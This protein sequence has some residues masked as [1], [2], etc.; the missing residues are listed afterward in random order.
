MS[1]QEHTYLT[2]VSK[3]YNRLSL[4]GLPEHETGLHEVSLEQIFIKL[5]L[6]VEQTKRFSHDE[7]EQFASED[8][9]YKRSRLAS[10]QVEKQPLSIADAL[11]QHRRLIVLGA[12]GSGK[13]TLLRW[14]AVT[15]ANRQQAQADRLGERFVQNRLP[16]M[17]ELRRFV[18]RLEELAK[19][20]TTFKLVEEIA[21]FVDE[22]AH[23]PDTDAAFIQN[24]FAQGQCLL[25]CDGL[26]EIADLTARQRFLEALSAFATHYPHNWCILTSRPH[27]V[28]YVAD[29]Q[30]TEIQP[31][32]DEDLK[33][34]IQHWYRSVSDPI[35]AQAEVKA[36]LAQIQERKNIRELARNPLLATIVAI[37]YRSKQMLPQRRVE[38][39]AQS[40]EVLLEKWD[41]NKD[42]R[43]SGF[44]GQLD[45]QAKLKL[46]SPVAYWL[47]Q[48][49]E[50]LA[51]TEAEIEALLV[52]GLRDYSQKCSMNIEK[53]LGQVARQFIVA[54]RDRSGLLQGR[55][56]G[57]LEFMH[58][59]FQEYLCA[60]YIADVLSPEACLD[61]VMTHLHE[62][63]WQEVH[64]LVVGHLGTDSRGAKQAEQLLLAVLHVYKQPW[65][66]L[67]PRWEKRRWELGLWFPRWQWQRRI[68]WLLVREFALA[69]QM[70]AD[71]A[72]EGRTPAMTAALS[73][74]VRG[75]FTEYPR[76]LFFALDLVVAVS[77]KYLPVNIKQ[78]VAT[79]FRRMLRHKNNWL[80]QSAAVSLGQ[81]GQADE[82]V[83]S[84]LVQAL[85]DENDLVREDAAKSLGRLGQADDTVLLA[86]VQALRDEDKYVRQNA[87][88]S[89]GQL[90]QANDTV[91]SA[92]VQALQDEDDKVRRS[93]AWSLGW[94]RQATET[95]VS[96]FS[97][98]FAIYR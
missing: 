68:A 82:I 43:E 48:K 86:L 11:H 37:L 70:F 33:Q 52:E 74:S 38:L 13:T 95:V 26:D 34:F 7:L 6:Q 25:L 71:C 77:A 16:V 12:P 67:L 73:N 30:K 15:F 49:T 63:W 22:D 23:F 85:Q 98:G 14:L 59:T 2:T 60:R 39:Y 17:L 41:H 65:R 90:G 27:S 75:Y 1:L 58:R 66:W 29:F 10:Q 91:L 45:W 3:I 87:A 61:A 72:P 19:S 83:I 92:L 50:R 9:K 35:S 20:P 97:T 21:K 36:L 44:I 79:V 62:S 46:L 4:Q 40:C 96:A 53:P 31:F 5:T 94:L 55:G 32:S 84:A 42:I 80:R 76:G 47:H 78:E 51:A 18:H 8:V 28:N 89:L 57:T 56:D 81:L 88:K 24:A 54:I 69:A 64:L 93:A